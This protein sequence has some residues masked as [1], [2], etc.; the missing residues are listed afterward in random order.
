MFCCGGEVD[1]LPLATH[2]LVLTKFVVALI[3]LVLCHAMPVVLGLSG[4][5]SSH[6]FPVTLNISGG[7]AWTRPMVELR[8]ESISVSH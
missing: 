8:V 2:Q 4:P 1:I 7:A 6:I 5:V 3:S